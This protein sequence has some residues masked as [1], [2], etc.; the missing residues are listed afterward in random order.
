MRGVGHEDIAGLE[1]V[2]VQLHLI[3]H[4]ATY[5][6]SGILNSTNRMCTHKLI[7]PRWIGIKGAFATRSPSGAK[8]AQE[9][10]SRSLIFVLIAVCCRDLPI[11]SATL[12][13]RLA[14]SVSRMGSGP[15]SDFSE[16]M[17]GKILDEVEEVRCAVMNTSMGMTQMIA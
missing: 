13:N 14:K 10:S 5:S 6:T 4:S 9:K 8:R 15:P 3:P 2:F 16:A 1:V 11:A 12:M 17:P 7:E